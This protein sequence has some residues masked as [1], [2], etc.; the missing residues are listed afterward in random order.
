MRAS[1]SDSSRR[2]RREPGCAWPAPLTGAPG[3]GVPPAPA[4]FSPMLWSP[5]GE[6]PRVVS[7]HWRGCWEVLIGRGQ[8]RGVG[9]SGSA[10]WVD[11]PNLSLSWGYPRQAH[12]PLGPAA[13]LGRCRPQP[14]ALLDWGQVEALRRP[15]RPL[16]WLSGGTGGVLV[17]RPVCVT[18]LHGNGCPLSM[19]DPHVPGHRLSA[20][21]REVGTHAACIFPRAFLIPVF[22]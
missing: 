20:G 5:R 21:R 7:A 8:P 15:P 22:I 11:T 14:S 9:H 3:S 17:P 4:E 19:V 6:V 2:G 18:G 13:R 16:S 12:M 10:L 1:A